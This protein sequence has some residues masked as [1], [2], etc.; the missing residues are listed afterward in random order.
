MSRSFLLALGLAVVGVSSLL[1]S[2]EPPR[3][4]AEKA[5]RKIPRELLAQ[6]LEAARSVFEFD[7]KRFNAAEMPTDERLMLWS[8]RWLNAELALSEKPADRTAAHEAHVER[9]KELE[10]I[11]DEYAKSGRSRKSDA[12]AAMSFRAE[13]EIRLLEERGK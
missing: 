5:A 12:Q 6:R 8:E 7:L 4:T 3:N 11:F 2:A 10:K 9:L 13:A 1:L